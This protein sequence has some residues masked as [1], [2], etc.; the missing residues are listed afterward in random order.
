MIKE[1]FDF[2]KDLWSHKEVESCV[3]GTIEK[4]Q[5]IRIKRGRHCGVY[6]IGLG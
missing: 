4:L 6:K 3:R 1:E 2:K 5:D